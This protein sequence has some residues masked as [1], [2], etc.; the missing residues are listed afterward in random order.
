MVATGALL[1]ALGVVL[2]AFGAHGL[3]GKITPE[4]IEVWKT[5]VLYHLLHALGIVALGVFATQLRAPSAA[6]TA[7]F[8]CLVVGILFFSGSIYGL[9]LGGPRWLG[10]ITPLG[11]LLFIVGWLLFAWV[12][13]SAPRAG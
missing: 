8:V 11:G 1:M 2:G 3:E 10:P 12:A 4:K 13:F 5:G 7:A 6:L 9:A